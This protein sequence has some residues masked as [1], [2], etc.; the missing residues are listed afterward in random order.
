MYLFYCH[1]GLRHLCFL[2]RQDAINKPWRDRDSLFL[3]SVRALFILMHP[4]F[5]ISVTHPFPLPVV[6]MIHW[7]AHLVCNWLHSQPA[8]SFLFRPCDLGRP[9]NGFD[10]MESRGAH[11]E[12][13]EINKDNRWPC[14]TGYRFMNKN[15]FFWKWVFCP[16]SSH[17]PQ[18]NCAVT[19]GCH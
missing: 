1:R 15:I 3:I 4:C 10:S 2:K 6:W 11:G 18:S 16:A 13:L 9:S 17:P 7:N 8:E 5:F 14:C 19:P 12:Y